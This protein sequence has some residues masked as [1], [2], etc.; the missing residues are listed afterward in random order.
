MSATDALTLRLTRRIHADLTLDVELDLNRECGVVFGSSGA[1]KTTLLRLIA[2]LERPDRGRIQL[3]DT[4]LY[5]DRSGLNLPLR[6]RRIGMIFQDDLLFPHLNVAANIQF[7]LK[8][9][10]RMRAKARMEEVAAFCGVSQLLERQPA[11]LSGGERQRVGL[12][13]ALAPRPRLL[14]CDEPVSALDIT[15]RH[16][17]IE[18][19]RTVQQAEAIPILYVTHSTAEAIA[20]GSRLFLLANGRIIDRGPP[21]DVLAAAGRGAST[22][23]EGVRNLFR[24]RVESHAEDRGETRLR[25]IDGP[26]L[27]VPFHDRPPGTS[28]A[29]EVRG[30]EILLAKGP[31]E[32]LSARNVIPGTVD[33]IVTHGSEAEVLVQTEAISW[34]VSVVAPAVTALA[35][36]PGSHLHLIVKA[37]SCLILDDGFRDEPSKN[38]I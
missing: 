7:G 14:L 13:R 4:V 15:S 8:G 25:L 20:L 28:L 9:E 38:I 11:T 22:W 24:G 36:A 31:I 12:A 37:R 16:T 26:I 6:E 1:G 5:D 10:P 32:G 18:R 34:I 17:L 35:L 21:L 19:L 33:R 27:V 3:G 29:V 30:D 23:F 2:G